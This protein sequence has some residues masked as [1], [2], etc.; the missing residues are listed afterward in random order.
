MQIQITAIKNMQEQQSLSLAQLQ[1]KVDQLITI[2]QEK[3]ND[4]C[5]IQTNDFLDF[6]IN[7]PDKTNK[8]ENDLQ[9]NHFQRKLVN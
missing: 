1:V 3:N 6:P 2:F 4:D 5:N 7:N 9:D 8:L